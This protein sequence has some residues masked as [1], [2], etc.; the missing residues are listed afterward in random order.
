LLRRHCG[1]TLPLRLSRVTEEGKY[2]LV[3]PNRALVL[4]RESRA[5]YR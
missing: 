5:L 1:R 3:E 2:E 4:S